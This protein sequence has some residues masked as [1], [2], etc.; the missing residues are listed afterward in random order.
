VV[1]VRGHVVVVLFL[2]GRWEVAGLGDLLVLLRYRGLLA[3]FGGGA[4]LLTGELL[5]AASLF[6]RGLLGRVFFGGGL[7]LFLCRLLL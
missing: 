1:G 4:A 6:F 2:G 7:V 5:L 3:G